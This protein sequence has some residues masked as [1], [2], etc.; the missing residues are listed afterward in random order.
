VKSSVWFCCVWLG[1]EKRLCIV[2]VPGVALH[3]CRGSAWLHCN[4]SLDPGSMHRLGAVAAGP[5]GAVPHSV[6]IRVLGQ[7]RVGPVFVR[8]LCVACRSW[9][10]G[11]QSP[12]QAAAYQMQLGPVVTVQAVFGH[13]SCSGWLQKPCKSWT[14][15]QL[16]QLT[17]SRGMSKK[18]PHIS[19]MGW[20]RRHGVTA[21]RGSMQ[22]CVKGASWS[23]AVGW[24]SC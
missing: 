2:E 12:N 20:W 14:L 11:H 18:L 19:V 6:K 15:S 10:Q 23:D 8:K 22:V 17:V 5:A 24:G 4:Q 16:P 13:Q 21:V 7:Y 3:S 9:G 1:S